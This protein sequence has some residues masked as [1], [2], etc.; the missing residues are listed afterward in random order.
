MCGITGYVGS[1]PAVP[2]IIDE[3]K[4]L[5]Y[6]G[7]DSAGV[8]VIQNGGLEVIKN[9]GKIKFLQEILDKKTLPATTGIAHTRWATHGKPSTINAHPH[10][11]C[12]GNIAVVHNGII[13]NYIELREWLIS[14]GHT[15]KSETDTEV[16]PHLIEEFYKETKDMQ[17]AVKAA[18]GKVRGSYAMV[19]VSK[20]ED[21][22][23]RVARKDSPLVIGLGEGE[24]FVASDIPAVLPY[25]RKVYVLEDGDFAY[26]TKDGVRLYDVDGKDIDRKVLEVTWDASAAEKG[27]YDHFMIKE[28][29]E[30]PKGIRDTMR[31]RIQEDGSIKMPEIKMDAAKIKSFNRIDIVSCGTAYYAGMVG[32][33]FFEKMLRTPVEIDVASEFRYRDP[34]IDDKTLL[35]V[36]SQSGETADTLAVLRDAKKKGATVLAVVNVVGSSMAREADEVIYTWA[37]PEICVASTKAYI[38]QLT[39]IYCLGLYLAKQKGTVSDADIVKIGKAM[40]NL[41]AQAEKELA[42]L[43]PQI[44]EFAKKFTNNSDFF[45]LGR[46]FDYAVSLEGALKLKE[47][48]YIHAEAYAA[49]EMKHGPLALIAD[50]MPVVCIATQRDLYEKMISNVKEMKARSATCIG[51]IRESDKETEKSVDYVLR[52]PETIDELMPILTIIPLQLLAYY[53]SKAL[54][55]EIDQPRNL[56][57]SVTVE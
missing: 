26:I 1:K 35:I 3:L 12:D 17:A 23:I 7:Y 45:F 53:V 15:I 33:Y 39:A 4:R 51:I 42:D 38:T 5:E 44:E 22:V 52:V 50:G 56:A 49:G 16:L 41:P 9:V 18:V 8:A 40:Q 28:I 34:M 25:T 47:I 13:E 6:R 31:A 27:G 11:S 48:S 54:G 55:R 14:K 43:R 46:G 10:T 37:G 20:Y 24:N 2:I 32:K 36:I 29:L 57:K 19:V 21:G 30:Q